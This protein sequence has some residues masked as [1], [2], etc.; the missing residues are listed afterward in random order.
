MNTNSQKIKCPECDTL[1]SIDDVLTHQIE[2]KIKSD[3]QKENLKREEKIKKERESLEEQKS[4]FDEMRKKAET[5]F[6]K[7]VSEKIESEK[8]ILKKQVKEEIEK[9]KE[10]EKKALE[11][12]L[13]EK[14]EKLKEA[15]KN[16][17]NLI[18]EKQKL[19]DDK[20]AFEIE[21]A[22][23]L[24]EERKKIEEDASKKA[25]EAKQSE[26]DQLNKKLS[27]AIKAKDEL[28]RK[29]VQGSQQTQGE[30][31][32]LVLEELLQSSFI[33]DDITPVPKGV[34]GADVI[35]HVKNNMGVDCGTIV[36]ES[37]NTKNWS[38]GWIQKLKND[39]REM[40]ADVAVIVSSILPTGAESISQCEGVWVCSMELA[41]SLAFILRDSLIVLSR[42]KNMLVGK[43]EKM[44]LLYKYLT[45]TEFRQ[46]IEIIVETFSSMKKSIDKERIYFEKSWAEKEKQIQKV[47]KNTVGIHGDLSGMVS[48][49]KIESLELPESSDEE[50]NKS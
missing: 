16:E 15:R 17:L 3:L 23:Q 47:I 46:R 31:Q 8:I 37:K 22:R 4:E 39:Q 11:D 34:G 7:K 44:E 28:A 1:I 50:N 48:L 38:E 36:W 5:E 21:K 2:D 9:E 26:L 18:K 40:K 14:D 33:Y 49:Q 27:D 42:E 6:N 24:D 29:L 13:A 20:D 19:K 32:E 45:G 30:V 25:T 43:D 10:E 12:Q 35:Q 41:S